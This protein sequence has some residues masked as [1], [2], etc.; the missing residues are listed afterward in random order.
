MQLFEYYSHKNNARYAY[1]IFTY[2]T[3]SNQIQ[4]NIPNG[5]SEAQ[6][7]SKYGQI[8]SIDVDYFYKFQNFVSCK[9]QEVVM[10]V[11]ESMKMRK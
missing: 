5:V 10:M 2:L 11:V 9:L 3:V 7:L 6:P 8:T 4:I 1:D